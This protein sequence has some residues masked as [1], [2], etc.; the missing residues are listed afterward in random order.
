MEQ[1]LTYLAVERKVSLSMQ[2][3][4]LSALVFVYKDKLEVENVAHAKPRKHIPVVLNRDEVKRLFNQL[5]GRY[6]L[7]GQLLYGMGMHLLEL[8]RL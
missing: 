8:S 3:Q 7:V 6:V 5:K 4:A 1:F 2:N